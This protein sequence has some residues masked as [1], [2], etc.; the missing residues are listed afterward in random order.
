MKNNQNANDNK[1]SNVLDKLLDDKRQFGKK[2]QNGR[3][4]YEYDREKNQKKDR[5][6]PARGAS[7]NAFRGCG[8]PG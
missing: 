7:G 8:D 1:D 3:T 5:K 2:L 6:R 4:Y